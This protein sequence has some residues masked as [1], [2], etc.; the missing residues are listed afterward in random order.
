MLG[1]RLPL[2][3]DS[4]YKAVNIVDF[5]RRWHITCQILR[6]Y[7]YKPLGGN[8]LGVNR[9][10]NVMLVMILGG[11][12]QGWLDFYYVGFYSRMHDWD[13]PLFLWYI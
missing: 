5:W 11:L 3:F 8:R 1:L 2:N 6:D 13:L 4:P 7:L 12:W 9:V 10:F